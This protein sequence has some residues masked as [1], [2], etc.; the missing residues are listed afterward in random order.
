MAS[1]QKKW[2]VLCAALTRSP[3]EG[4]VIHGAGERLGPRGRAAQQGW[5]PGERRVVFPSSIA[6]SGTVIP[7]QPSPGG[8]GANAVE[9]LQGW[10]ENSN[11]N[12]NSFFVGPF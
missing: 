9:L 5:A 2:Q 3:S 11:S 10:A 1:T 8:V 7:P 6:E 4:P 12:D